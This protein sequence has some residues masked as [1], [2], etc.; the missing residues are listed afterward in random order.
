VRLCDFA[1]LRLCDFATLRLCDFATYLRHLCQHITTQAVAANTVPVLHSKFCLPDLATRGHHCHCLQIGAPCR[2]QRLRKHRVGANSEGV[3]VSYNPVTAPIRL[4]VARRRS[5]GWTRNSAANSD[6]AFS[7][8]RFAVEL[9]VLLTPVRL[10][11]L[12]T[13]EAAS[14]QLH[15][16]LSSRDSGHYP[17]QAAKMETRIAN[18]L[19][20]M[21][22]TGI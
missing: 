2:D 20:N 9:F 7:D 1:T 5:W 15:K 19:V 6:A 8:I 17:V 10:K 13:T 14:T 11:G 4:L 3:D 21:T 12:F 22:F 18:D 16:G